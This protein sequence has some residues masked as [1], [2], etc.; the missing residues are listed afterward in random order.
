V[1]AQNDASFRLPPQ[2][3]EAEQCVLGSM[4]LDREVIGDIVL[5]LTD[6]DFY[7]PAH[8]EVFRTLVSLYDRSEPIDLMLVTTDLTSRGRLVAAGGVE[9]LVGL[10]ESV[11]NSA[12]AVAYARLV[13]EAGERRRLA[14]MAQ[15]ILRDVHEGHSRD[16]GELLDGAEQKIFSI[17]NERGTEGTESMPTLIKAALRRIDALQ[18]GGAESSR[19]LKTHYADLDRKLNGLVPGGL[20]VIAGR[21]S[22]GKTSFALN[23]LDHVCVRDGHAGV[24]FTLEVTKEQIAENMLC[25]NARVDM[26]KLVHG[27]PLRGG[28]RPHPAGRGPHGARAALRGRH[29]RPHARPAARQGPPAQ[30]APR[31][32]AHRRG[33]P[34]APDPGRARRRE[35]ADGDLAACRRGSSRP[36]ASWACR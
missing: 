24:L 2:N 16:V 8:A 12:H 3:L 30:G 34:A 36:R 21:P 10:M 35:P 29:A 7:Q 5:F 17:A 9:A 20:Y 32:Q 22:M 27:D 18:D 19:G 23:I 11:P 31:H 28:L 4:L 1:I 26:H 33:L 6:E 15:E 14:Q 25:A 13:R